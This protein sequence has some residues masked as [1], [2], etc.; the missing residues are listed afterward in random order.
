MIELLRELCARPGVSGDEALVREY[1]IDSI[2][3]CCDYQVDKLGNLIC[4]KQGTAKA[5]AKVMLSAHMDEVGMVVSAVC[6]DGTLRFHPV[7]GLEP[8]VLAGR[9]VLVGERALPAVIGTKPVHLMDKA[10]RERPFS[11]DSLR[12]DL[13]AA[14]RERALELARPGDFVTFLPEFTFLGPDLLRGKA[15]DDRAGCA[16]LIRL[17]Q[18]PQPFDLI[19]AFTVQEETGCVGARTAAAQVEPDYGIAVET[20]TAGDIGDAPRDRQVCRLGQG[21]VLSFMDRATI[22]HRETL[23]K[24]LAVAEEKAIP[25]QLKEGVFGG[26]EARSVQSAGGGAKMLAISLA[27]RYLHSPGCVLDRRDLEPTLLLLEAV[28]ARLAG[29][30]E[31]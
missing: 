10:E 7:G 21:P 18:R 31:R 24:A 17:L 19:V 23:D 25:C 20:T 30:E 29:G 8:G 28:A 13:G 5:A 2:K 16:L 11:A 14:T 3:D 26:N 9:T 22:Y 1:I 6:D 12:L 27:C 15:L 4:H